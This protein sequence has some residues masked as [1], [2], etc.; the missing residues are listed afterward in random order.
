MAIIRITISLRSYII[1]IT[2]M[3]DSPSPM[4]R[5]WACF[6]LGSLGCRRAIPRLQKLAAKDSS[7]CPGWW[8]VREEA[9]DALDWIAGK[10]GKDRLARVVYEALTHDNCTA[11][12]LYPSK[13]PDLISNFVV[14]VTR[15]FPKLFQLKHEA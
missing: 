3:L 12:F 7:L 2:I 8:Y 6:G 11:E 4:I 9:E 5:F 1:I 10:P 14:F 15:L 13:E